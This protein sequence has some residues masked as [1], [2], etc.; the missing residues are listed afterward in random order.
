MSAPVL[1]KLKIVSSA[2]FDAQPNEG[3]MENTRV[4][5]LEKLAQWAWDT[6]APPILW[7]TG[8]AGTGKTSI[9]LSFCKRLADEADLGGSFFCSSTSTT[10]KQTEVRRIIPTLAHLLA[11]KDAAFEVAIV[12]ELTVEPDIGEKTVAIQ[13]K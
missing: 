1:D 4:Q 3:C 12:A 11:R 7:L 2:A 10:I 9:A 6:S 5:I 13:G 8:M